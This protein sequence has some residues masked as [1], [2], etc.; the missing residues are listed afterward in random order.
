[1]RLFHSPIA[2]I[3]SFS[4]ARFAQCSAIRKRC[5]QFWIFAKSLYVIRMK[6]PS[7]LAAYLACKIISFENRLP[8]LFINSARSNTHI[9]RSNTPFPIASIRTAYPLRSKMFCIWNA[10]LL[11]NL[12]TRSNGY[13]FA[14]IWIRF[15]K[16]LGA[17][18]TSTQPPNE[19]IGTFQPSAS[20]IFTF[21]NFIPCA[22]THTTL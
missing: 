10:T 22:R 8:P 13:C 6:A 14:Y 21:C 15:F 9:F 1:M 4:M 20:T 16:P 11:E 18:G 5:A 7:P 17:G 12:S 2:E 19:G 3:I